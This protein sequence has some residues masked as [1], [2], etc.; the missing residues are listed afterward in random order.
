M[1]YAWLGALFYAERATL[2]T[3]PYSSNSPNH[4]LIL[5][6]VECGLKTTYDLKLQAGVSVGQSGPV[7][8]H[9]EKAGL[10]TAEPGTRRSQR[11]SITAKGK[12]ELRAA[13][14]SGKNENWW[15][16]TFGFFESIP[17]AVLLAW[18]ASELEDFPKWLGYA[19]EELQAAAQR[20]EQEAEDLRNQMERLRRNPS[21]RGKPLLVGTTYRWLKATT[22]AALLK[23]QTE[24][25]NELAPLLTDLPA[26]SGLPAKE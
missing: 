2:S 4:I 10:L 6:L 5:A 14:A 16:G 11:Y 25:V 24:L 12:S 21:P 15:V 9:L 3:M 8:Q 1:Y 26:A 22:Q 7:L 13:I 18:L 23:A 19:E 17:R 20:T